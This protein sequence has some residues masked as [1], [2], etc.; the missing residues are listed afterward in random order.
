MSLP[1]EIQLGMISLRNYAEKYE[2]I[3]P[4]ILKSQFYGFIDQVTQVERNLDKLNKEGRIKL[5]CTPDKSDSWYLVF[6]C[7]FRKCVDLVMN[8]VCG[9][10]S[11]KV[12]PI[13]FGKFFFFTFFF[14]FIFFFFCFI[15]FYFLLYLF[16]LRIILKFI[17]IILFF[18]LFSLFY[19]FYFF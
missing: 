18:I 3:C 12:N 15:L 10:G 6:I 8:S 5:F 4:I 11:S 2:K 7:D 9:G 17:F 14:F 13:L 1:N 16:V 19:L